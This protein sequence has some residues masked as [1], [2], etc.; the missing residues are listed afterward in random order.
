MVGVQQG[1]IG[2]IIHQIQDE[3][4]LIVEINGSK[5]MITKNMAHN[6]LVKDID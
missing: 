5:T 1:K 2:K 3:G 4:T 6:I